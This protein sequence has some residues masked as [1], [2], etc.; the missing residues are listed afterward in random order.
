MSLTSD[1]VIAPTT[2]KKVEGE[3]M[4][5]LNENGPLATLQKGD[6]YVKFDIQFPSQMTPEQKKAF[7][8]W[9]EKLLEWLS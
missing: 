3:G 7:I 8:E 4:P 2:V 9:S 6:L 5:I 1:E